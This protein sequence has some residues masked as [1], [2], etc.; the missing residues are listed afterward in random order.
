MM[1]I[2][3]HLKKI[4]F[5]II[6]ITKKIVEIRKIMN[7][8][9]I[10]IIKNSHSVPSQVLSL[11]TPGEC[12]LVFWFLSASLKLFFIK[13]MFNSTFASN[14]SM[15]CSENRKIVPTI[16]ICALITAFPTTTAQKKVQ[17]G[18]PKCPHNSP[19]RSNNGFG[20]EAHISTV[21]NPF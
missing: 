1:S 8:R 2:I 6:R 13:G 5:W 16:C 17:N 12:R 3:T 20:I 18:I 19:A 10:K 4:M 14:Y 15:C 7:I 21:Q 9:N 11:A